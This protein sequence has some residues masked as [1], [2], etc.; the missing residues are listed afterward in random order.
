MSDAKILPEPIAGYLDKLNNSFAKNKLKKRN[1]HVEP[2]NLMKVYHAISKSFGGA[3]CDY[4][5]ANATYQVCHDL[6]HIKDYSEDRTFGIEEI[7]DFVERVLMKSY[8]EIARKFII[9]RE[10]RA[11]AREDKK[12]FD[13]N[14]IIEGYVDNI[15]WRVKEN[16][17][18]G[19]SIG[20]LIL[21]NSGAMSS[22]Y[23]LDKIYPKEVRQAHRD[24]TVHIHDLSMLTGYC[25]GL[26]LRKIVEEGIPGL[27]GN[28]ESLPAKHLSTIVQHAVNS[29]GCHQNE[30]S[31][32][33][34][35]SSV[36]TWFAPFVRYDN[37]TATQV[38][39]CMQSLIFGLNT[40]SR[41]GCVDEE[42]K[43]HTPHG[44]KNYTELSKGD[45]IFT[46]NISTQR[47]EPKP[48]RELVVKKNESGKMHYY[49][50]KDA[51]DKVWSQML[52]DYHRCF[53]V[54]DKAEII[55]SKDVFESDNVFFPI[56]AD[57]D[58][59]CR[60]IKDWH[61][62]MEPP[63]SRRVVDY[64]GTVWCPNTENGTALF[65]RDGSTFISGNSQAPFTNF[66]FD[67]KP[68]KDL[69]DKPAVIGGMWWKRDGTLVERNSVSYDDTFYQYKDFQP[70]MDMI[71]TAFLEL[72][73]DGDANGRPFSYPIPTYNITKDFDW[74]SP[75][76]DLLFKM[77]G[78]YGLPY[79]QNF[80]NSDLDPSAVRSLCCRL[81]L[82]RK[83][84]MHRGGG[85]FGSDEFT[86]SLGVATLNLP[87]LA[88]LL[89]KSNSDA[90]WLNWQERGLELLIDKFWEKVRQ[91]MEIAR[92][93]LLLKKKTIEHFTELGLYPYTRHHI[94]HWNN[95]FLTIGLVGMNE[96]LLN[97]MGEN[98]T[99][100]EAR[101]VAIEILRRMRAQIID[102]QIID[103]EN[104]KNNLWNLE[105]TPAEGVSFRLAKIDKKKYP[106][107]ITA[108]EEDNVYY[109]NSTIPPVGWTDDIFE[110]LDHQDELQTQYTGGTVLHLF[111]G[112]T[113][114]GD[115]AKTLIKK[116][117]ENYRLPYIS[118]T[119]TYSVCKTHGHISG[120]HPTCPKC[121]QECEVYSRVVGYYRPTKG[122]NKGKQQEFKERVTYTVPPLSE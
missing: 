12:A 21:H 1:G 56:I 14:S 27:N 26:S 83:V 66:T 94:R 16:S 64:D 77:A 104:K 17:N 46:Y 34:A 117:C 11:K 111:I 54:R 4:T 10:Q 47:I 90:D 103:D 84:L 6:L 24:G 109:T 96:A 9:Y 121:G 112:E 55:T 108:G 91:T 88:Y 22:H 38:K 30:V 62:S 48:I 89:K 28:L 29:L 115:T 82:D 120:K 68:P 98:I 2:F 78:K 107:I 5:A 8:P 44:I 70:E 93:S 85:L 53:V 76:S 42:T 45:L 87:Q 15:D 95:H 100:S 110:V 105:A 71:N 23:W 65:F 73:C 114:P 113:I 102:Y 25:M 7:Q 36:D 119:P 31:G 97:L 101:K 69:A 35:Y 92:S 3:E 81:Q 79:F 32:A 50:G 39:Q 13:V 72:F 18:I 106:D 118:L 52:T 41:W 49:E 37:L 58:Y 59:D 20:A 60:Y 63:T 57:F 99:H 75:V 40:P 116:V 74:D 86:G 61:Y 67:L 122:W 33:V 80:V 19:Y 51:N 43:I